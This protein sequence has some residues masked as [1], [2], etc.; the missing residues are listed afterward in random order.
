MYEASVVTYISDTI[1]IAWAKKFQMFY[2]CGI[3][4]KVII[5]TLLIRVLWGR[6]LV[7]MDRTK[8]R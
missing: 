5:H 3:M 6:K 7:P 2:K 4:F 8:G 1:I